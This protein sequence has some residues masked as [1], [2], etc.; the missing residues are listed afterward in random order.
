MIRVAIVGEVVLYRD[1]LAH[2]LARE[3]NIS[4][5]GTA[6]T[7]EEAEALVDA[8]APDIV[9]VDL[10]MT[11]ALHAV[12]ELASRPEVH[13]V[14]LA[15]P[16]REPAIL[17][18][19]EAGIAG[20]VTREASFADLVEAIT[21]AMCG[22]LACT[23]HVAGV[24]LRRISTLVAGLPAEP[25]GRLTDREREIVALLEQRLSNKEIAARLCIEVATVKNHVHNI[26]VKLEVQRRGDVAG[27]F[28]RLG[29]SIAI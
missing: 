5:A 23:P 11:N 27:A 29:Q 13:I 1:G 2:A 8:E 15:V 18:C 16:D 12:R 20:L 21:R 9:L 24:L 6:A 22:D 19:A 28:R 4:M 3:Q 25:G 14:A 17:A 7:V 26:L 10:T